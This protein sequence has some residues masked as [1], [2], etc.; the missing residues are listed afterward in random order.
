MSTAYTHSV[1][2]THLGATCQNVIDSFTGLLREVGSQAGG[3]ASFDGGVIAPV[4]QI[5]TGMI[6]VDCTDDTGFDVSG[7]TGT[8]CQTCCGAGATATVSS[9]SPVPMI[10]IRRYPAAKSRKNRS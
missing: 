4:G 5:G 9:R 7:A 6:P 3:N 2:D 8:G 10:V 1:A